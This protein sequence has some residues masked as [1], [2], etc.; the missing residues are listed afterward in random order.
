M[1]KN[2]DAPWVKDA[3]ALAEV[4]LKE[5]KEAYLLEINKVIKKKKIKKWEAIIL[6]DRVKEILQNNGIILKKG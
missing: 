5:G 2:A 4:F 1:A 6:N 3:Q